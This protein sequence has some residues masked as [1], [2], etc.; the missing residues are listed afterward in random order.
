MKT[1]SSSMDS[2]TEQADQT[3][4]SEAAKMEV[5]TKTKPTHLLAGGRV[6]GDRVRGISG[7]VEL[8]EL[9]R[10]GW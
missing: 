5:A 4:G 9:S 6:D 1:K 2:N 10:W 3:K 7:C 8:V